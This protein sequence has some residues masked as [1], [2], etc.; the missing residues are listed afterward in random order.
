MSVFSNFFHVK[1]A[2]ILS[3]LGFGGGGTGPTLAK[4]AGGQQAT[5]GDQEFITPGNGYAYHTFTT[6]GPAT[7]TVTGSLSTVDVFMVGGGGKGSTGGGGAGALIYKTNV[8]VSA[9]AYAITV[10][11]GGGPTGAY[12]NGP[13]GPYPNGEGGDSTALGYTAAGGGHGGVHNQNGTTGDT[14]GSGGGGAPRNGGGTAGP[15]GT[16]TGDSGGSGGSVSPNNGWGNDGG[17]ANR[18]NPGGYGG[19]GGGAGGTGTGDSNGQGGSGLAYPEF[20]GPLI[21]VPSLP[22]TYAA[23]GPK[24]STEGTSN[25]Y[26]IAQYLNGTGNGGGTNVSPRPAESDDGS[27]GIVI[28]RYSV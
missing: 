15:G 4:A 6:T 16:G 27:D 9:Q 24:A 23:G 2:P 10:G 22:G 1:Q 20:A 17:N 7:F 18:A 12:F 28:I 5:G 25:T 14:G 13:A 11:A 21:G 19:G 26:P 3:M 8:P